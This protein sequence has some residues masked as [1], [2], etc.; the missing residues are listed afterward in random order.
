MITLCMGRFNMTFDEAYVITP[1]AFFY[2]QKAYQIR[3][4]EEMFMVNYAAWQNKVVSNT[5]GRGKSERPMFSTFEEFYNYEEEFNDIMF[6]REGTSRHNK[7]DETG[8]TMA[9]RNLLMGEALRRVRERKR[10]EEE[11]DGKDEDK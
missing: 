7:K 9:E 10:L 5:K 2:Y 3:R 6:E 1:R 11:G 8:L 4:Q